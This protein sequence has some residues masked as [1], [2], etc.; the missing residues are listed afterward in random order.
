INPGN[1]GGPLLDL[2]GNV[3]GVNVA[4]SLQGENISFSL[5]ANE[6]KRAVDSVRE[7]GKISRAYLGVRYMPVT[8]QMAE[9]NGLSVDYGAIILRGDNRELAVIPGSPADK[10]GLEEN[11]IIL[12]VNGQQLDEEHPLAYVLRGIAVGETVTLKVLHDGAEKTV[13]VVLEERPEND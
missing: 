1:S 4:T 10:A 12:E 13:E 3:I 5:P 9:Q 8:P 11:D 2:S 6:V 7:T